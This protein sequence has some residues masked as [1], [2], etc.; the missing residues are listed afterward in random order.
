MAGGPGTRAASGGHGLQAG[1][2]Q[3]RHLVGGGGGDRRRQA[4]RGA[5]RGSGRRGRGGDGVP[6]PLGAARRPQAVDRLRPGPRP[7]RWWSTPGP[8]RPWS[9]GAGRCCRRRGVGRRR[10]RA[11]RGGGDRRPRRC[12]VRQGDRALPGLARGRVAGTAQPRTS[13][14]TSPPRSSTATTWSSSTRTAGARCGRCPG[15]TGS[16]SRWFRTSP[17]RAPRCAPRRA[18]WP[19]ASSAVRDDALRMAADL[20]VDEGERVLSANRT[21]LERAAADGAGETSVDRLRLDGARLAS[22]AEG[23]R[24]VAALA[25]PVGEVVDG[26]V[27]PNGLRVERVRVPLGV[28]GRHLREPA[29]RDQRR[30]RPV[31]QGGQRRLPA[32]LVVG[33]RLQPG[34]GGRSCAGPWR[35]PACPA[36]AVALVEDGS[37]ETAVEFMRLRGVIDC[38]VPRGGP[39]LIASLLEHATVP[40]VLDGDGNCH[41]YVDAAADLDMADRDR[42]ERQDP[43]ARRVQRRRDPARPLGGGRRLPAP[44]RP[45]PGRGGAASATSAPGPSCPGWRRPPRRT[46]PP[47]S[48]ASSSAWPWSTTSTPP[49]TT[50]PGSARATPRP[51]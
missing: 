19:G 3:D 47:S 33:R 28:V 5:R 20:L 48:W 36:D 12:G 50:S 29:Q 21:D 49:S 26:W 42:G 4:A 43:A 18:G 10:L 40:Y 9:T 39:A 7:A 44:G 30:R 13:P 45:G 23:L 17:S 8:G 2:G 34:G 25:D 37:H 35:R 32:G 15:A 16:L 51:S 14:R 27:R 1:G 6:A 11:R 24:T 46:S 38:L 22:M 31:P 41:V